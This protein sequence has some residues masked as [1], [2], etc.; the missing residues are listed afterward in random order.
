TKLLGVLSTAGKIAGWAA[1]V[2]F[3]VSIVIDLARLFGAI[4][5]N[6]E[7]ALEFLIKQLHGDLDRGQSTLALM[8]RNGGL[9]DARDGV[10]LF[11]NSVKD[12][13]AQLEQ[14]NPSVAQL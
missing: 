1:P 7:T 4:M 5:G 12:Y 11:G 8:F 2:F 13:A 6:E 3:A 14:A 10:I 9:G